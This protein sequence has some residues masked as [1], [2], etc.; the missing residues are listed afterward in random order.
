M[1]LKKNSCLGSSNE[2]IKNIKTQIIKELLQ[3]GAGAC[4]CS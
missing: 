4:L 1:N 3:L 2:E